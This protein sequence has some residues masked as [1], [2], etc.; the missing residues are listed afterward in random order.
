MDVSEMMSLSQ[1]D[2]RYDSCLASTQV[3]IISGDAA[4]ILYGVSRMNLYSMSHSG[5]FTDLREFWERDMNDGGFFMPVLDACMVDGKRSII[6]FGFA[7]PVVYVNKHAT[8][9]DLQL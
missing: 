2:Q 9:S 7:L 3:K 8:G 5:V 4:D 6:P 1:E